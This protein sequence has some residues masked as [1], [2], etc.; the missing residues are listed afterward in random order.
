MKYEVDI[1]EIGANVD[2]MLQS[3]LLILFNQDAPK[4]LRPYCVITEGNKLDGQIKLGDKMTIVDRAYTITAV[5]EVAN[6]NLYSIGHVSLCF[7]GAEEAELPGHIHLTP[8]FESDLSFLG[9]ITIA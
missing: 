6:E 1:V 7:D 2:A 9:K 5:G 8:N 4:D 3:G